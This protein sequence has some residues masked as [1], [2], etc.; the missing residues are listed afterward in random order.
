M[1]NF[2]LVFVRCGLNFIGLRICQVV[3]V[4]CRLLLDET[5]RII[6][7]SDIN[8]PAYCTYMVS[9]NGSGDRLA[10]RC[11]GSSLKIPMLVIMIYSLTNMLP[12]SHDK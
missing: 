3:T 2:G 4:M 7:T 10:I 1:I 5:R 11:D 12:S 9:V 8:I 6:V